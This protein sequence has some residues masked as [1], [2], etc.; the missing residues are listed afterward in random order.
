MVVSFTLDTFEG[1]LDLLLQLVRRSQISVWEIRIQ[2][3]I[4]QFI[5]YIEQMEAMDVELTGEFMVM[6]AT[7]MR[8][9][10]RMLLPRPEPE[11]E[12]NLEEQL[13]E[14]EQLITRLLQYEGF[15]EAAEQLEL[16]AQENAPFYTRACP[17]ELPV[18]EAGDPLAG[19]TLL[20]LAVMLQQTLKELPPEKEISITR[21][22]YSLREQ[23]ERI[24][25]VL[26]LD[27][28]GCTFWQVL[29]DNPTRLEIVVT[30]LALL[31]LV[32]L[33]ELL[34]MQESPEAEVR[35]FRRETNAAV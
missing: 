21:E 12:E 25:Y 28:G 3:I 27:A 7:L 18:R 19:V 5:T 29:S 1:P 30:F 17:E 24:R 22:E 20:T 10:A 9:K 35:L 26:K 23:M 14:E 11:D 32:R 4:E 34:V 2:S 33:Q 6:A 15:R 13:D 31:E 16:L 8:I